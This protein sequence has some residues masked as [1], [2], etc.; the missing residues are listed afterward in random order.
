MNVLIHEA[1]QI[2][3]QEK[4]QPR[5]DEVKESPISKIQKKRA[6]D[7]QFHNVVYEASLGF[8]KGKLM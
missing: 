6:V 4:V 1:S 5:N 7:I 3:N 2:E 8:R